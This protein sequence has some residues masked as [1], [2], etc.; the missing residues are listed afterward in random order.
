MCLA[1]GGG[2]GKQHP[3]LSPMSRE[4]LPVWTRLSRFVYFLSCSFQFN[5]RMYQLGETAD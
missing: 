2:A 3:G 1:V 5:A 4:D